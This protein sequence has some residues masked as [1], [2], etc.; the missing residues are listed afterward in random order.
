MEI[1]SV[2]AALYY[3]LTWPWKQPTILAVISPASI[4][5]WRFNFSDVNVSSPIQST[6]DSSLGTYATDGNQS[7]EDMRKFCNAHQRLSPSLGHMCSW[8]RGHS[9]KLIT[10]GLAKSEQL[11]SARNNMQ[12]PPC[13][14]WHWI[15]GTPIPHLHVAP[16]RTHCDKTGTSALPSATRKNIA[17]A[18]QHRSPVLHP[19]LTSDHTPHIE[20]MPM[21]RWDWH[22]LCLWLPVPG[23]QT[24]SGNEQ[25]NQKHMQHTTRYTCPSCSA[26]VTLYQTTSRQE[27]WRN[28]TKS[29]TKKNTIMIGSQC[30]YLHALEESIGGR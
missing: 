24:K 8:L 3:A 12:N 18:M 9:W 21:Y 7:P 30:T 2:W 23:S 28:D 13:A 19:L 14:E 29:C 4:S 15:L 26:S 20:R 11:V 22:T 16:T 27:T 1:G 10:T 6:D 5:S 17:N 25:S